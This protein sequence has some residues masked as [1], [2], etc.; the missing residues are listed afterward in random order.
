MVDGLQII[1]SHAHLDYPQ[2][3][4]QIDGTLARAK[5]LGVTE[6]IAIGVKLSTV[7]EPRKIAEAYDNVWFSAGI[8]PHE[9]SNEPDACNLKRY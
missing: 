9:A 3:K 4:G 7:D 8:H 2:F 1:D 6:V 5:A